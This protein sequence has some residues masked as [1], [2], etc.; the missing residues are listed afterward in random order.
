MNG[1]AVPRRV[2]KYRIDQV[3]GRGAVGIV[4]KGYDEQIDRPLA[5]KTLRSE[6]FSDVNDFGSVPQALHRRGAIGG[7]L[8]ASEHRHGVRP[9]G[10]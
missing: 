6:I 5:I 8:P 9:R 4:Y 7:S 3:I 1:E 2:G 10:A